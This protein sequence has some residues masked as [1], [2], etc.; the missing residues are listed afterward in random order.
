MCLYLCV[1]LAVLSHQM[2]LTD[3]AFLQLIDKLKKKDRE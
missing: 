2:I 1:N 3:W